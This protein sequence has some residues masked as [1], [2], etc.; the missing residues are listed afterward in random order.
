MQLSVDGMSII[1]NNQLY[2]YDMIR[3]ENNSSAFNFSPLYS[4]NIERYHLNKTESEEY[5][6]G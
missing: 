3:K 6:L 4:E 5:F 2:F 1:L